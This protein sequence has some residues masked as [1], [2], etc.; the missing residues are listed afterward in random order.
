MARYNL[1]KEQTQRR[2]AARRENALARANPSESAERVAPSGP[3]SF[4]IKA[5]DPEVE[6]MIREF[7]M[8]R[9]SS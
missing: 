9:K 2:A 5:Q 7:E 6:R 8:R 1:T 4:P 3:M